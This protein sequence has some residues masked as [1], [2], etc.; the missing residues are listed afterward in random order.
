MSLVCKQ[1]VGERVYLPQVVQKLNEGIVQCFQTPHEMKRH[2]YRNPG[3]SEATTVSYGQASRR[4]GATYTSE[5][6][7][8][9]LRRSC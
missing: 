6:K 2:T 9:G 3:A 7:E 5:A 1:R 4:V 8:H